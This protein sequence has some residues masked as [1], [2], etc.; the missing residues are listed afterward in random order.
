MKPD[1]YTYVQFI[2]NVN[3]YV[4][5]NTFTNVYVCT[6]NGPTFPMWHAKASLNP[7]IL[8]PEQLVVLQDLKESL[9]L[10]PGS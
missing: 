5:G 2:T 6:Y 7:F 8:S 9:A 4:G 3:V 10:L 1:S